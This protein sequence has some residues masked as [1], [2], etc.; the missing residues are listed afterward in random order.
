MKIFNKVRIQAS[1]L[2][3]QVYDYVSQ[4][5][6]QS[7]KVFSIASAYGQII[8][9]L[10]QLTDMILFFIEDSINEMNMET[11]SRV[12]SIQGLARLTGHDATRAIASTGE[13][14][15]A[16][17]SVPVIQG[18]QVIVPNFTRIQ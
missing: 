4:K 5:F 9:V 15:F 13:I 10:S 12:Q 6:E 18:D 2:Y 1:E 16:I 11:A 14:S 8:F 7:G 17:S 3:E